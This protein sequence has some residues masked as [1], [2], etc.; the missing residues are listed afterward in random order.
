[1]RYLILLSILFSPICYA[2]DVDM[3]KIAIIESSNNATAYNPVSN[4]YG[5]YQITKPC[6]V[7]WNTA[8]PDEPYTLREMFDA[9]KSYRV[10][11][12]YL[13]ERI[14]SMLKHYGIPDTTENRLRAYNS[15]VGRVRQGVTPKET[16][17]YIKKYKELA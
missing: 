2:E 13:N 17:Q 10:A 6:L 7:D 11:N 8:H 4:A 16:V 5:K 15:G 12:W 14:P 1:M 3:V 9:Q